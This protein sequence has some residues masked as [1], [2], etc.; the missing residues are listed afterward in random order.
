MKVV[1][2]QQARQLR[3]QGLSVRDIAQQL[4]VS[5][6]SVSL[7]VRDIELTTDQIEALNQNLQRNRERFAYL[8]RC[9]GANRNKANAQLRKQGYQRAGYE[10]AVADE[11]FRRICCLYWCEGSK[12]QSFFHICNCDAQLLRCVLKWLK[13]SRFGQKV[14]FRV[15]YYAE[16]GLSE[17][18]IRDWWLEQ[19]PEL[20]REQVGNFR[21][22]DVS[23]A[24]QKKRIG[25]QPYGTAS[26]CVNSVELLN[27]VF[28]GIEYLQTQGDW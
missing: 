15:H 17:E 24:S 8:S 18:V 4:R 12:T 23:R 14:K 20:S 13:R 16:N 7:W 11:V 6:G 21:R 25:K 26:I 9:G 19:L 10:L 2:R 27:M 1:E 3:S 5:R 22:C 28:G